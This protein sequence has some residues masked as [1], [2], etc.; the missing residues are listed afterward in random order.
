MDLKRCQIHKP[1]DGTKGGT[2]CTAAV[3]SR[4][5]EMVVISTDPAARSA[6]NANHEN[7]LGLQFPSA[8]VTRRSTLRT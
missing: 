6:R 1:I 8:R 3:Y 7:A 2:Q 4:L 5:L